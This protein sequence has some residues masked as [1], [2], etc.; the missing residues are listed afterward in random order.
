MNGTSTIVNEYDGTFSR[1][2]GCNTNLNSPTIVLTFLYL[3]PNPLFLFKNLKL[4]SLVGVH[5][6][7]I[8]TWR[9]C[10]HECLCGAYRVFVY[11]FYLLKD[12]PLITPSSH[13]HHPHHTLITP[14][15]HPLITPF[16][17]PF[18]TPSSHHNEIADRLESVVLTK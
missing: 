9:V 14:S 10:A 6:Y 16:I 2:K 3:Q 7:P 15:S 12:H 18:I 1:L 8:C 11:C 5:A 13:P 17:T 4:L